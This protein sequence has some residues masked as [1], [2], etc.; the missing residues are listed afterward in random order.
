MVSFK[1]TTLAVAAIF[2]LGAHAQRNRAPSR[3]FRSSSGSGR[4]S[5][6]AMGRRPGF[7][8][9]QFNGNHGGTRIAADN[10]GFGSGRSPGFDGLGAKHATNSH[11]VNNEELGSSDSEDLGHEDLSGTDP[12]DE[13]PDLGPEDSMSEDSEGTENF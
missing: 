6:G 12:T 8:N 4:S 13:N 10:Q 5:F 1:L 3:P 2:S 9:R 7:P 11:T